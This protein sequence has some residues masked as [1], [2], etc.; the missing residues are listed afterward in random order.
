VV[1][2]DGLRNAIDFLFLPDGRMWA[3]QN[4]SDGLGN[5]VP[6][7]EVVIQIEK[8]KFYG[9][10][11]CYTPTLGVVP[12]GT[13]EVRDERVAFGPRITS[14][15]QATPALFT[16]LAHQAP[17][18]MVQYNQGQFPAEYKSNLF[19]AYHGSW[20]SSQPRDCKVQRI[21]VTNGQPTASQDFLTG[22]RDNARQDCAQAWGRPAGV[23]VGPQGELYVSD[24]K[25]GNIYR[26]VYTG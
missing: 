10:P 21:V 25:N 16:D 9:W 18:G 26:I 20:N 5:D 2:A 4:G 13:K 3:T 7:E 22:F 6:P 24:D 15:D 19:I 8:G 17:I 1:W 11:W 12:P 23:A 14:C